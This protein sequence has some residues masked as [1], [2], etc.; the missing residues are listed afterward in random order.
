MG[1]PKEAQWK[2]HG[3]LGGR[4]RGYYKHPLEWKFQGVGGGVQK[5]K[6]PPR[7]MDIF[8]NHTFD[9]QQINPAKTSQG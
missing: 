5:E 3:N 9:I 2:N 8:W 1:L 4:G 6:N 7:G